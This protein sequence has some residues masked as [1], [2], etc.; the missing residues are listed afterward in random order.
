VTVKQAKRGAPGRLRIIAG[1]WRRR[2][3]LVA[4]VPGLRPTPERV[5]ETLFN[6]L[7]PVIEGARC[8]DLCAGTGALGFEALSR[9][10]RRAVLVESAPAAV[11]ALRRAA[12][13]LGAA[14]AEIVAA[15]ARRW[16]ADARAEAFDVVFLDP[17][18][19]GELL[20]DLCRLLAG[21]GWLAPGALVY[22]EHDRS[23]AAPALPGDWDTLKKKTAGGV[24]YY[25]VSTGGPQD[26]R[27]PA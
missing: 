20:P 6:W 7:A 2:L 15:D 21:R 24:C 22:L 23:Q 4:E 10:A 5:R 16:L 8:L 13:T 18:Y 25:L 14:E 19:A 3:L 27:R 11:A 1:R 26:T 17:P 12:E 9:G